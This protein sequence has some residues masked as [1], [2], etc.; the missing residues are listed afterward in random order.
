MSNCPGRE[1]NWITW[2]RPRIHHLRLMKKGP[3]YLP[4]C[5]SNSLRRPS[6]SRL[7]S[8]QLPSNQ[9]KIND[10]KTPK[11]RLGSIRSSS[12][13]SSTRLLKMRKCRTRKRRARALPRSRLTLEIEGE[14]AGAAPPR[15]SR[16]QVGQQE[17][18]WIGVK[19]AIRQLQMK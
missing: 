15:S 10:Q 8:R 1:S 12:S 5:S 11:L 13:S 7:S 17:P 6:P 16:S 18:F 2:R 4:N 3:L 14:E 9:R 19:D